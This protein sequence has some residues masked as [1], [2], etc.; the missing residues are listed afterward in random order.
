MSKSI[1]IFKKSLSDLKGEE[2]KEQLI[3]ILKKEN[4]KF[5]SDIEFEKVT[6]HPDEIDEE[7]RLKI[8]EGDMRQGWVDYTVISVNSEDIEKYEGIY[9]EIYELFKEVLEQENIKGDDD[10][11]NIGGDS[12]LGLTLITKAIERKINITYSD[13]YKYRTIKDLGDMLNSGRNERNISSNIKEYDYSH[14]DTLLKQQSEP[15]TVECKNIILS[16][17]TGFLGMHI[18]AEFVQAQKGKVYCLV[19]R[20]SGENACDRF[21]KRL[22][23]YFGSMYDDLIGDRIIV[24][25]YDGELHNLE[26]LPVDNVTHFINSLALVKHYGNYDEFY[27]VNVKNVEMMAEFCADNNIELIQ[28]STL[29]VSGDIVEA[30]KNIDAKS[31]LK[32]EYTEK[33]FYNGQELDNVYAYTKFIAE[34]KIYEKIIGNNLRAKVLR[35]GNLSD[36]YSDGKFQINPDSNAFTNRL[37]S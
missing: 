24:V 20:S 26:D 28:I 15:K 30:A 18:I 17:A 1:I 12:M 7:I 29:S 31:V 2:K 35:M 32:K 8:S 13:L 10:F 16:G 6:I 22:N 34:R 25:E 11:F 36:R 4:I 3:E 19:R 5:K 14:I 33:D 23:Y 27:R 21:K 37:K 9:L